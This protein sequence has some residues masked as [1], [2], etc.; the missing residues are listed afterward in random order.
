MDCPFLASVPALQI[1]WYSGKPSGLPGG[2]LAKLLN[3]IYPPD[4]ILVQVL[5]QNECYTP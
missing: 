1:Q 2:V 3:N 5:V 4:R